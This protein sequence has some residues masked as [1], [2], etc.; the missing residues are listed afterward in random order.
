M[1][2]AIER[3]KKGFTDRPP[4]RPSEDLGLVAATY[5]ALFLAGAVVGGL[6]LFLPHG[7]GRNLLAVLCVIGAAALA[8]II[9]VGLAGRLPRWFLKTSPALSGVLV[10]T[11]IYFTGGA[12]AGAYAMFMIWIVAT[13]AYFFSFTIS[14]VSVLIA[15]SGY[16]I[17]LYAGDAPLPELH[18]A[19]AIAALIVSAVVLTLMRQ[20]LDVVISHLHDLSRTDSLTGLPNRREFDERLEEELERARRAGRRPIGLVM[21]DLDRFKAVNDRFGHQTGDDCLVRFG[22]ILAAE[23]RT[24]D[25]AAR[26]GGDEFAVLVPE[27]EDRVEAV[28]LANRIVGRVHAEFAEEA[29][30]LTVS[31]GVSAFPEDAEGADGL[32]STADAALYEAKRE[33]RDRTVSFEDLSRRL[34]LPPAGAARQAS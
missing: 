8:G 17:A 20:R 2:T 28:D 5:G 3:L 16:G 30:E 19:F 25:L 24:S 21:L 29:F 12:S 32:L 15:C 10:A 4:V 27:V 31:A 26:M 14:I 34:S 23:S 1:S 11:F 33:G 13:S 22:R 9:W 6:S 18:L 7:P